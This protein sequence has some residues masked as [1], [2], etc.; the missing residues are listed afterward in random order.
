VSFVGVCRVSGVSLT[1]QISMGSKHGLLPS[2][3]PRGA[4]QLIRQKISLQTVAIVSGLLA[5]FVIGHLYQQ[6]NQVRLKTSSAVAC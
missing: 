4:L 6:H 3:L 2:Y 1:W 5:G